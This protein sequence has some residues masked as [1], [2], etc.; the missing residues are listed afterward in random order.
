M[1]TDFR[2][3]V[4][5]MI[6]CGQNSFV[7]CCEYGLGQAV[8]RYGATLEEA[9]E[10][11]IR[12]CYE[13]GVRANEVSTATGYVNPLKA[14]RYALYDG[15][16]EQ[17]DKQMGLHTGEVTTFAE[18]YQAFR[19]QFTHLID[20]SLECSDAYEEYM[21]Y[22]NPS[23]LYSATIVTSLEK[24]RDGYQDGVKYCNS[25]LL[26][27]GLAT[28][29][30]AIM[31]VWQLV[32]K[33]K[34]ITVA[35]LKEALNAN[36]VGYKRLRAKV[37]RSVHK[38]GNCDT[39]T[40]RIAC[41]VAALFT[42]RV[43]GRKNARGGVYKPVLHSA[44]QF[45]WQGQKTG[46]TPD[47]RCKGEEISKNGSPSP[48]M[49]RQGVT[50]LVRSALKLVP[51]SWCESFCVDVMM[52]PSAVA[53]DEGLVA[54]A[55]V[56]DTYEQGGGQSIQF[57]IFDTATLRKAQAEPEKY[58]NLQVRVCGWNVLWNNL[59]RAEQ[60]AYIHRASEIRS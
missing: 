57:N 34:L 13:T 49:D 46:A 16:D 41:A 2:D 45:V 15:W 47:G 28:A 1:P 36:W 37:R 29:V 33:E 7:F 53:G 10:M 9:R 23:S 56:L 58:Q 27:C 5:D 21:S 12:G 54:M 4:L 38:F 42:D 17:L 48:G 60:D 22:I 18:F 26:C 31:A 40:D 6:R 19:A 50:A 52:H 8:M 44:M 14:V 35:Q 24:A 25:A 55:G 32:E 11:D 3:K 39:E 59:S 51:A 20:L 43:N 30:D